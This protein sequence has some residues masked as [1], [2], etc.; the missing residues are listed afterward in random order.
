MNIFGGWSDQL[1]DLATAR[2]MR[3]RERKAEPWPSIARN[4]DPKPA[5]WA[6]LQSLTLRYLGP[7]DPI[8]CVFH[9]QYLKSELDWCSSV[10]GIWTVLSIMT[11]SLMVLV[12]MAGWGND[13]FPSSEFIPYSSRA[14]S[15]SDFPASLILDSLVR[16]SV[17]M[18]TQN[19]NPQLQH[20]DPG[21]SLEMVLS[22]TLGPRHTMLGQPSHPTGIW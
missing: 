22:R 14:F 1:G 17:F 19:F 21:D 9:F 3:L 13:N 2:Q 16:W 6:P 20:R 7:Q 8:P 5:L 12:F 4:H 18:E 10:A 11:S 15:C